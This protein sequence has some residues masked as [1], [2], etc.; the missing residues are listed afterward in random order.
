[1]AMAVWKR[2]RGWEHFPPAGKGPFATS[3]FIHF[4]R[5]RAQFCM[6]RITCTH[7]NTGK[8]KLEL[9]I[10]TQRLAIGWA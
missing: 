7:K 3:T 6:L 2:G 4:I 9:K 5:A 8:K 10:C 1:M